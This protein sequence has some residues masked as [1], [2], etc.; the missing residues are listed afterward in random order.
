MKEISC[1]NRQIPKYA[2]EFPKRPF[3]VRP[4][5]EGWR[6]TYSRMEIG[7]SKSFRF[8]FG[9]DIAVSDFSFFLSFFFFFFFWGGGGGEGG[10][11][12]GGSKTRI[13]HSKIL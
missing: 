5:Y 1:Q 4:F 11:G 13:P 6:G 7:L 10:G 8:L 9:R 12:G 3:Q 2:L